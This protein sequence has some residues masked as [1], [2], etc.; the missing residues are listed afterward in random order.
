MA[1]VDIIQKVR[2]ATNAA[3]RRVFTDALAKAVPGSNLEKWIM[4]QLEALK[5]GGKK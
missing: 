3:E 2:D 1:T 4:A 5:N